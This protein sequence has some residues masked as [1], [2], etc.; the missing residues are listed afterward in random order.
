MHPKVLIIMTRP[1]T[2]SGSSR[3]LDAYFH[4][5]E[6]DRVAQIF[7]ANWIPNKGHCGEMYQI[8]DASLAKRWLHR[9]GTDEIGKVYK[10]SEMRN[11]DG[12]EEIQ[13]SSAIGFSYKIG[14]KHTP[15]V[16]LLRGL[17]WQKKYWCTP[18]LNKWLDSYK[19]DVIL[20]NFSNHLFTQP[21]VLYIA[22][23][24]NIPVVAIIGDD[25]YFNNGKSLSPAYW[26]FRRKFKK[27][28]EQILFRPNT[29]AVYANGAIRDKYNNYFNIQGKEIYFNSTVQRRDFKPID[30]N[31][32]K[33][34][35]FGSIR[36]GR[37]NALSDIA[38]ALGRINP[39]YRLDVYTNEPDEN[40]SGVLKKN[41]YVS[42]GGSIPYREVQKKIQE[43]DLFIIAEGFAP[44]DIN[45]TRYS[46][47]TKASDGLASG[48]AILTYGPQE[49][50]VVRY[51]RETEASAVCT[52]PARLQ[53]TIQEVIEN[54]ELQKN[55][56][57]QAITITKKNHT[58]ESSTA[59]FERIL[60]EV[61]EE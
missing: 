6:R 14:K 20:W 37:N 5:W 4:F 34:S 42:Y 54:V 15:F 11:E 30:K 45:M 22:E 10:Y 16:E 38:N 12:N 53:S 9:I 56:Y 59:A 8:T 40:I 7:C 2:T 17:L 31:H 50:G 13:D 36:L 29:S 21:I 57:D 61:T 47:S 58:V 51:M 32:L 33:A 25:Y 46:L 43:S 24:Y 52:D 1:Y 41:P 27:F 28:A 23:K 60:Q 55:Y 48:V 18:K 39:N 44:E 3:S 35:Y 49:A 26:I 19:P